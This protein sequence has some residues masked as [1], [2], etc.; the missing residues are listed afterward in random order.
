M[1]HQVSRRTALLDLILI[2]STLIISKSLL[3]N[4]EALWAYAGPIALLLTLG[5]ATWRL[6]ASKQDWRD[7]GVRRP[8]KV[9]HLLVQTLIAFVVT[10]AV[11]ILAQSLAA[12]LIGPANEATQAI[13]ARYQGRFD[14]IPGNLP[15]FLFWLGIAWIIGGFTEEMLFRGWL[16]ARLERVFAGLPLA[17]II[18]VLLQ[19]ILF[20]QQ[21]FY[22]Q[23]L[24]G[25]VA[26]S[27]I[28]VVSGL[29]FLAFRR[30]LWPLILSHGLSNTLGMTLLYLGT[31]G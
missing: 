26:N 22:Y 17:A 27:T 2:F 16:F 15:V 10:I 29:L 11:G 3:L 5:V 19:A 4:V 28:A 30:N 9:W 8:G 31:N 25:W 13:D 1:R 21:H 23:G 7:L 18:G 24:S 6:R 20:G 14:N 12:S